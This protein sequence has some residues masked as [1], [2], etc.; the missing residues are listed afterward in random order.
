MTGLSF[1]HGSELPIFSEIHESIFQK[2]R[3]L[4]FI[5][6]EDA[7]DRA[8]DASNGSGDLTLKLAHLMILYGVLLC[9]DSTCKNIDLWYLHLVDHLD[10]FDAYPWGLISYDFFVSNLLASREF[11]QVCLQKKTQPKFDVYGYAFALQTWI[12]EEDFNL[13]KEE[14]KKSSEAARMYLYCKRAGAVGLP[15]KDESTSQEH[16]TRVKQKIDYAACEGQNLSSPNHRY[17][18]RS[19][20]QIKEDVAAQC[21]SQAS[22]DAVSQGVMAACITEQFSAILL[23]LVKQMAASKKEVVSQAFEEAVL[24]R[25]SD[26]EKIVLNITSK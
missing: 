18:L 10:R 24:K 2:K 12:Y 20:D 26:L 15:S 6:I 14:K 25:F 9:R 17:A 13:S 8:C 21:S 22:P 3:T 23:S 16:G 1:S 19:A 7:F 5:E 11:M 4:K